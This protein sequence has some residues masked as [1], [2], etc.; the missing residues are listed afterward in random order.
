MKLTIEIS[1]ETNNVPPAVRILLDDKPLSLIQH[2]ELTLSADRV[3]PRMMLRFP[4]LNKLS[5]GSLVQ[6]G[7]SVEALKA[8]I[9]LYKKALQIFSWIDLP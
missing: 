7:A 5:A 6:E 3:L 4:N 8:T 2:L 9:A 1:Q